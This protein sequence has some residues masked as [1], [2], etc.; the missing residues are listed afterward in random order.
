MA[1]RWRLAA[2]ALAAGVALAQPC[3]AAPAQ[4]R[5]VADVR[6]EAERL[7]RVLLGNDAMLR[8]VASAFDSGLDEHLGSNA[9]TPGLKAYV[10]GQMRPAVMG[11]F[12]RAAPSLRTE[13]STIIAGTMTAGEI[14]DT[15]T[16]FDSSVGR[17]M[18]AQIYDS[19]QT[20]PGQDPAAIQQA[21]LQ[22]VMANLAPEDYAP[23]LA[24][25]ASS[26]AKKIEALNPQITA[27]STAWANRLVAANEATIEALA[28]KATAEYLEKT[29]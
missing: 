6:A 13:L 4:A 5:P 14:A 3:G 7:V 16:F 15:I 28:A 10:D 27:A 9:R 17:K 23:L 20:G 26:A 21:A 29:K 24:F 19:I 18:K 1:M 12:L 2:L 22:S 25:G 8:L 11:I